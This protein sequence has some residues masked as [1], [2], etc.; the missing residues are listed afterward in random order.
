M[1]MAPYLQNPQNAAFINL[2]NKEGNAALHW[3]AICGHE[4]VV[5]TLLQ[6]GADS[7]VCTLQSIRS[8]LSLLSSKI[9]LDGMHCSRLNRL[10]MKRL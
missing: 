1:L 5:K 7:N 6:I 3:A 4:Q 2:V 10:A 9:K 8:L